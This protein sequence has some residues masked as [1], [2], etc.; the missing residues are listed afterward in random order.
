LYIRFCRYQI[1]GFYRSALGYYEW[2]YVALVFV[3]MNSYISIAMLCTLLQQ[4]C[5]PYTPKRFAQTVLLYI[6]EYMLSS[7]RC[8]FMTSK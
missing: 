8:K 3:I 7:A 6:Y 2:A 4:Y 1:S 5:Q